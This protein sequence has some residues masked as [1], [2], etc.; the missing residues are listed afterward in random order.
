MWPEHRPES[1][2]RSARRGAAERRATSGRANV[3]FRERDSFVFFFFFHFHGIN[4]RCAR[5]HNARYPREIVSA[6]V[7][8][9]GR[10]RVYFTRYV[11]LRPPPVR[12]YASCGGRAGIAA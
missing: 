3:E 11:H 10:P 2:D 1:L 9:Q 12:A 8:A 7:L 4:Y 5:A 6:Y